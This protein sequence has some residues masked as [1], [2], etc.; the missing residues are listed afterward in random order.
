MQPLLDKLYP[1]MGG[2][3]GMGVG[4]WGGVQLQV[5]YAIF[6]HACTLATSSSPVEE[7]NNSSVRSDL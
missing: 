3:R 1:K 6:L 7:M 4:G 5:V 2:R